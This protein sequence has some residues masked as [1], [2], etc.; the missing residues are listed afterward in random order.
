MTSSKSIVIL[1]FKLEVN[2]V[3]SEIEKESVE[4]SNYFLLFCRIS[5]YLETSFA[6]R[7]KHLPYTKCIFLLE[8]YKPNSKNKV[9]EYFSKYPLLGKISLDYEL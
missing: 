7:I 2:I 6:T 3:I 8:A 4:L 9:I 5:E 1:K